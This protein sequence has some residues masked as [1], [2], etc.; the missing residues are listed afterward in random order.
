MLDPVCDTA[1]CV[2][3]ANLR[4]HHHDQDIDQTVSQSPWLATIF[5][6]LKKA[7]QATYVKDNFCGTFHFDLPW[8]LLCD[9]T[10]AYQERSLFTCLWATLRKPWLFEKGVVQIFG[11]FLR[12]NR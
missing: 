5:Q 1:R 2:F 7:I 3:P 8:Y 12:Y 4:Q 11:G 10:K 9:Y 6:L